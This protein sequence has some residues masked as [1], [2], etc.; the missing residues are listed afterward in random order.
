MSLERKD[1]LVSF[2]L[3]DE[4]YRALRS[5]CSN[6]GIR[7]LSEFARSALSQMVEARDLRPGR[8]GVHASDEFSIRVSSLNETM[9]RLTH[10]VGRLSRLIEKQNGD[11]PAPPDSQIER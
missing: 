9:S 5:F 2:R 7:N 4:E 8:P 11:G 3:S 10:A 1:R 6:N